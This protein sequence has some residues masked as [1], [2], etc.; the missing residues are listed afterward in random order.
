MTAS[1]GRIGASGR[2]ASASSGPAARWIAPATPPP[3]VSS[4]LAALT[5]H[6]ISLCRV[7]SPRTHSIVTPCT[8]RIMAAPLPRLCAAGAARTGGGAGRPRQNARAGAPFRTGAPA[9][10]RQEARGSPRSRPRIAPA[11][12]SCLGR[13][14][15][16]FLLAGDAEAV[17][18]VTGHLAGGVPFAH[19]SKTYGVARQPVG[20]IAAVRAGDH[21]DCRIGAP[22]GGQDA[23]GGAFIRDRD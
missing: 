10:R 20:L 13:I 8:T 4:A 7:M 19:H 6:S 22:R 21:L 11:D 2:H 23:P 9:P 17:Q 16:R 15:G 12:L 3:L 1:P 14:L 18:G 5:M